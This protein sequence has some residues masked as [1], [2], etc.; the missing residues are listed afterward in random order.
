[1]NA[2]LREVRRLARL[3]LLSE[4]DLYQFLRGRR[5]QASRFAG[6]PIWRGCVKDKKA[7]ARRLRPRLVD[8]IRA[9][10]ALRVAA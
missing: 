2:E 5:R 10:R 9:Q 4:I 6:W 1:M 8:M 7:A 3:A